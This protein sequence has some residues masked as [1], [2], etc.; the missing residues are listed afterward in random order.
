MTVIDDLAAPSPRPAV[1]EK[2]PLLLGALVTSA[3]IALACEALPAEELILMGGGVPV[4]LRSLRKRLARLLYDQRYGVS[5]TDFADLADFGLDHPERVYYSPAHWGTL[6]RALPVR[7]VGA[8][9][10]F[11][12]LG[13]GKGRMVLEAAGRYPFKRVI[14]VELAPELAEV[15]RANVAAARRRLRAHA[16]LLVQSD[17]LDYDIPDDVSVVFLNNP[18]RGATFAAAMD[19]LLESADRNPR[20]ITL[21]YFNPVEEEHLLRTGRFRHLRTVTP[22][23]RADTG[24][25]GTT[26][27]YTVT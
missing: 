13:A 19:R 16:V 14:G 21:I 25:F 12:D 6:R 8:H 4:R 17:V 23:R 26:R 9:D 11:L 27:V 7:D 5:T 3:P 2:L 20:P 18:F 22:W 1:R 24:V 10:V 15:A